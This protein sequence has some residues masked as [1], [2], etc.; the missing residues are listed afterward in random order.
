MFYRNENPITEPLPIVPLEIFV[1]G[2]ETMKE[3]KLHIPMKN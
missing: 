2:K 3:T 1:V